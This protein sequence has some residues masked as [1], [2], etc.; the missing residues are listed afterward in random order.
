MDSIKK[1]ATHWTDDLPKEEFD[2]FIYFLETSEELNMTLP[3]VIKVLKLIKSSHELAM[4]LE[5]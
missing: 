4:E 2:K 3:E 1:S 5:E